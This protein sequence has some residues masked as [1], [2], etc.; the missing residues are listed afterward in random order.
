MIPEAYHDI[1]NNTRGS[2]YTKSSSLYRAF[3]PPEASFSF[4]DP[5]KSKERRAILNPLF[6]RRSILKLEKVLQGRVDHFVARLLTHEGTF[7]MNKAIHSLTT[8]IITSYCFASSFNTVDHPEFRHPI[9][10]VLRDGGFRSF[11]ITKHFPFFHLLTRLPPWLAGR[12]IPGLVAYRE[13][14]VMPFQRQVEKYMNDP[15][16]L[17]QAEHDTIFH[18]LIAH[19]D[20]SGTPISKV[21]LV[22]E[23]NIMI[24]AGQDTVAN[25]CTVAVANSLRNPEIHKKL[26]QELRE[27][28]PDRST[29][30]GYAELEKLP[31]LTAFIKEALRCSHGVVT[32][33]PRVVPPGG[34]KI[35]GFD[36]PE[37]TIVATSCVFLHQNPEVF[38]NP[39][40]FRPERWLQPNAKE[41]ESRYLVAFS[42][43]P[44]IC[45]GLNLAWADLYLILGNMFRKLDI[46]L[47][48]SLQKDDYVE[49]KEIF[50]PHWTREDLPTRVTEFQV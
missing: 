44:R 48:G 3:P 34:A 40:E 43:G 1:Y 18:H 46:T 22:K 37:G 2:T 45:L 15:E 14:L 31:Y 39:T 9:S 13:K 7:D 23:A 27:A 21:A 33:L 49:F 42:R 30:F 10:V 28:W 4:T 8:D 26:V 25:A 41:L 38:D 36:L 19:R 32:P 50:V 16:S 11:W 5:A 24:G 29:E 47:C 35:A 12:I 6:S 20:K 17:E